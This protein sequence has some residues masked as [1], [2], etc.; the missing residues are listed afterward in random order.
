MLSIIKSIALNGVQ[1]FVV[2]VQVDISGGIP[3]L[4]IV[5]LPDTSIKE[6]KE[7]VRTAIKNSGFEFPSRR[8][9]IN[10]APATIRKE[11]STFDLA[12]AIA[13]LV[14]NGNVNCEKYENTIFFGEL[15]LDG[16]LNPI[17]GILPMCIEAKKLGYKR[18]IIP[19]DN[20]NEASIVD[21]LE[22]IPVSSLAQVVA[23]LNY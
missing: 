6:S 14:A 8:I 21:G 7:R 3:C 11:G 9:V 15:G 2:D 20:A 17:N 18:A 12:I 4:E 5:G 23:Y 16:N 1:G 19:K 22:V 10:L 13:I